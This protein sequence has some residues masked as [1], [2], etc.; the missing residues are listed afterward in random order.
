MFLFLFLLHSI[1]K[2]STTPALQKG[3]YFPVWSTVDIITNKMI[4]QLTMLADGKRGA[5][6]R[7]KEGNHTAKFSAFSYA[8]QYNFLKFS[9][10]KLISTFSLVVHLISTSQA[11]GTDQLWGRVNVKWTVKVNYAVKRIVRL[12]ETAHFGTEMTCRMSSFRR[13]YNFMP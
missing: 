13:K 10:H 1:K 2:G 4:Q 9:F 3:L 6:L 8:M 11:R 12:M 7:H 5:L